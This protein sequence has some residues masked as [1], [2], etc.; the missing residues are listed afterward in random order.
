MSSGPF[1]TL[2]DMNIKASVDSVV[3][4]IAQAGVS[5]SAPFL[6]LCIKTKDAKLFQS[7]GLKN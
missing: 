4:S 1:L 2:S 7:Y 5:Y 6:P 3:V